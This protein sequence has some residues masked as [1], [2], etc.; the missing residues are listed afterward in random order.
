[1]NNLCEE[2]R[3]GAEI[4]R[5]SLRGCWR[6]NVRRCEADRGDVNILLGEDGGVCLLRKYCAERSGETLP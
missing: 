4:D 3:D 6:V 5:V 1:M 2:F